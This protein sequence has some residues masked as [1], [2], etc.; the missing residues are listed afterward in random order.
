MRDYQRQK[1]YDWQQTV[2]DGGKVS[3][4]NAQDIINYIW[5]NEKLEYPPHVE[6][7]DHRTTKW[8]GKA[9]RM[10]IYLQPV[11]TMR[12]ILHEIAHSMTTD[13]EDNSARHGP[14]FVGVY[15]KLIEKYLK[16]PMPLMLYQMKEH[17][18]ECNVMA[19]PIFLDE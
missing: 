2:S 5:K 9:D 14:W 18:V 8:A 12:T 19:Y 3:L 15:S 16:V 1:V 7:I 10:T 4:E 17:G 6:P 13:I 11:V